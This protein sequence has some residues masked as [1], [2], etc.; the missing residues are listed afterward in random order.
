ML[1]LSGVRNRSLTK[2]GT[3]ENGT[4]LG[5]NLEPKTSSIHIL[6]SDLFCGYYFTLVIQSFIGY[7]TT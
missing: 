1:F 7:N 3:D 2:I 5:K 6:D 4:V